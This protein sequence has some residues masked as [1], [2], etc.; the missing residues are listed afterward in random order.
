MA[1][2]IEVSFVFQENLGAALRQAAQHGGDLT[3][4]MREIAVYLEGVSAERF[5]HGVG[6]G[7]VKW[8][9]SQRVREHGGQ[10]LVLSGD[11]QTSVHA[12][13]TPTS[14]EI[15]PERSF[16]SAVY[17]AIHQFGGTIRP[18][19]KQA[20][21]F[22]G[23]IVSSVTI[24]ARPYVGFDAADQDR[25]AEILTDFMKGAFGAAGATA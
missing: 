8:K 25:M 14:V 10:T 3:P 22:G 7:G 23:R 1:G 16:G 13:T 24:P 11:L 4:A 21:H 18:K 17:A 5:A 9:V 12:A 15:G 19:V 2:G 6:P 20:L